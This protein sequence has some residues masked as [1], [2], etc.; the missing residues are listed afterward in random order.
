MD[1]ARGVKCR[2]GSRRGALAAVIAACSL[3]A[4]IPASAVAGSLDQQQTDVSG[5]SFGIYSSESLAQTFKAGVTGKIDEVDLFLRKFGGPT[6]PI[7]VE[8]R[9]AT[10]SGAGGT[11]LA[12]QSVP[13]ATVPAFPGAFLTIT[14]TTPAPVTAGTL[15]A[16]VASTS[17]ASVDYAWTSSGGDSYADGAAFSSPSATGPWT[18]F[19]P[20]TDFAFRTYAI[21]NPPGPT[22]QRAAA[23]KKCKKKRSKK[24]RKKCRKKAQKLPV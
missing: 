10:S 3:G 11:V 21:P 20:P 17:Q 14:F 5:L 4:L 15:Y 13:A 2:E 9:D 18:A 23:L 7:N 19:D 6:D 24:A 12:S 1:Y 22:G 16:I 8:V